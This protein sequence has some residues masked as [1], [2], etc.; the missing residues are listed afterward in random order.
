MKITLENIDE[1]INSLS[2][3]DIEF[4]KSTIGC[5]GVLRKFLSSEEIKRANRLCKQGFV[6]KGIYPDK[7]QNRQFTVDSSIYWRLK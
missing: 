2:A 5:D 7:Y 4:I 3:E 6:E 1:K